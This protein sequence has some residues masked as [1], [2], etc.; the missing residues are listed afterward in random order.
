MSET[1]RS[2]VGSREDPRLLQEAS[3]GDGGSLQGLDLLH[4]RRSEKAPLRSLAGAEG[5]SGW[6]ASPSP[7]RGRPNR[8]TPVSLSFSR[9]RGHSGRNLAPSTS[10]VWTRFQAPSPE[11]PKWWRR[12]SRWAPVPQRCRVLGT[13]VFPRLPCLRASSLLSCQRRTGRLQLPAQHGW[14]GAGVCTRYH[15]SDECQPDRPSSCWQSGAEARPG[16]G[17]SEQ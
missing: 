5:H 15:T 12:S 13:G 14:A 8:V 6:S 11:S 16:R 1:H 2:A 9:G 4:R 17:V 3:H 7:V 10:P